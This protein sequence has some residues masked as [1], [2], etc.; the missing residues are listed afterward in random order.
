MLGMGLPIPLSM[1]FATSY[2]CSCM[3]KVSLLPAFAVLIIV[4]LPD[5]R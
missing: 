3:S 5:V 2:L 1:P 4:A